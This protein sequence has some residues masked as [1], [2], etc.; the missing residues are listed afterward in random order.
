MNHL[1]DQALLREY[2]VNRSEAAFREL[3]TRHL[4]LVHSTALRTVRDTHLAED[5]T[6]GV[7]LALAKQ[8]DELIRHAVL[9]GWLHRTTRNLAANAVRS[10]VRRRDNEQKAA[11]MKEMDA[12]SPE[13]QWEEISG[14]VDEAI[15]ELNEADRDAV[16]LRYFERKSAREIGEILGASEEAAQKRITRAIEKLRDFLSKRGIVTGTSALAL[17]LSANAVQA[18]PAG[19]AAAITTNVIV[20]APPAAALLT[21]NAIVMTTVQKTLL[22]IAVSTAVVLPLAVQHREQVRLEAENQNLRQELGKSSVIVNVPPANS[23]QAAMSDAERTELLRLRGEVGVLR[24]QVRDMEAA[25]AKL[26]P[27]VP[28]A[29]GAEGATKAGWPEQ[30]VSAKAIILNSATSMEQKLEALR[31]LRAANERSDDVVAAMVQ[32]YAITDNPEWQADVFRQLSGIK[33]PDLKNAVLHAVAN[34]KLN[35]KVR[36]EATETLK[37]FLPDTDAKQWLEYLAANESDADVRSEASRALADYERRS[38]RK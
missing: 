8:S 4:D 5:V 10:A 7:F 31:L 29:A 6:Q 25:R 33:H 11:I 23:T 18:A 22:T 14:H 30:V 35:S 16:L 20:S 32:A 13:P 15:A 28:K 26:E 17:T 37:G 19:M 21:T 27:T 9:A 12:S 2:A 3:V 36:E 1:S 24:Q 34:E 38:D